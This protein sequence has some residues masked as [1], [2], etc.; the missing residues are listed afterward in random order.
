MIETTGLP[1]NHWERLTSSEQSHLCRLYSMFQQQS[2][3]NTKDKKCYPFADDMQQVIDYIDSSSDRKE[4]RALCVGLCVTG[5][6]I[7][8][9]SRQIKAFFGKC[10]SAL[11]GGFQ[12]LGYIAIKNKSKSKTAVA[13]CLPSLVTEQNNMRQWTARYLI[14]PSR[15][16]FILKFPPPDMPAIFEEDLYDDRM[17]AIIKSSAPGALSFYGASPDHESSPV[18]YNHESPGSIIKIPGMQLTPKPKFAEK[19]VRF[20][21]DLS[22]LDSLDVAN[23]QPVIPDIIPS[24]SAETFEEEV[25]DMFDPDQDIRDS[26]WPD[27]QPIVE[28]AMPRSHSTSVHMP[29]NLIYPEAYN[30]NLLFV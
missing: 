27:W 24:F 14:D 11:N 1:M 26:R 22:F 28:R 18:P 13:S 7:C 5:L 16:C 4:D 10:K 3:V 6:F 2:K 9:N 19:K 25:E 30:S 20:A 12:Q 21:C 23:P 29:T 8:L 15:A 17:T